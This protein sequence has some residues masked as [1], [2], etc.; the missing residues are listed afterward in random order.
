M[1]TFSEVRLADYTPPTFAIPNI[2]LDVDITRERTLVINRMTVE[3]VD[4]SV[5]EIRLN[6]ENLTLVDC[7]VNGQRILHPQLSAT[8]LILPVDRDQLEIEIHTE[9]HP[10]SN[11]A[12]MGFYQSGDIYCTQCEA[13]GFRRIT[14]FLDRPDILSRFRTTMTADRTRFPILLSNGNR[15]SK[16]DVPGHRHRVEWED[17]YPKPCYLF[18]MVAGDLGHVSDTYTTSS[19]KTVQIEFYV[20]PGNE[21][22]TGHAIESLKKSMRW[23][24]DV[25]GLEYDLD[26]YMVVAVDAFNFGAMENKGLNIFNSVYVLANPE[27]ATDLDYMNIESVI[28]HEYF[29][30]YTGNRVTCRDWFQL[31]LKEGLTVFRDQ[32]FSMDMN[33]RTY[34]RIQDVRILRE[35]Q[36]PEDAGPTS[37]PIQPVSY[38]SIDNFYT[39]TVYN[40]GAEVI[41]MLQTMLGRET[42]IHGVKTYLKIHDGTAATTDDFIAA[43]ESVSGRDLSQFKR[44]Y[45]QSGTPTIQVDRRYDEVSEQHYITFKQS[46]RNNTDTHVNAPFL[47]PMHN[48]FYTS[49]GIEVTPDQPQTELT[50]PEVTITIPSKDPII[51]SLNR[52]FA[53]PVIYKVDYRIDELM[54]L[55]AHETNM[56]SRYEAAQELWLRELIR[57][58]RDGAE[59]NADVV[60]TFAALLDSG[61]DPAMIAEMWTMPGLRRVWAA[62]DAPIPM[63]DSLNAKKRLIASIRDHIGPSLITLYQ[64]V[65]ALSE[66]D[67]INYQ[68][69]GLRL[70]KNQ[71]L[72]WL[73]PL[74]EGLAAA[75]FAG[76]K[77]MT[78][79]IGAL[80][81]LTHLPGSTRDHAMAIFYDR[82]KADSLT[83]NK[84][85]ASQA[86][87]DIP[88]ILDNIREL[89]T[90][91][92]FDRKNP[93]KIRSL[94]RTFAGNLPHFHAADGSGYE[95][96]A[97]VVIEVDGFNSNIAASLAKS[98]QLLNRLD[99]GR[100]EHMRR[101]LGRILNREDCSRD[102]NEICTLIINEKTP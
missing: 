100:R 94:Y 97:D 9:I 10:E 102:V 91:P 5:R 55:L 43:M 2:H 50:M 59:L 16:T 53:A 38:K 64:S 61:I 18:A 12:L 93:N 6:G 45:R 23:D 69:F 101:Q 74:G 11:D 89:Q 75:Q 20:D 62:F 33:N 83:I 73:G 95:F 29:H 82:W 78:D 7:F 19:G 80:N 76:A 44:W 36:Y 27:S 1:S 28:G 51:P 48:A 65:H 17:P 8:H 14:Y 46:Y 81:V 54:T 86:S 26:L 3:R 60:Q 84:Y 70:L 72:T 87:A 37:H 35:H 98:F 56:F 67:V 57:M 32:E 34:Q 92:A 68:M 99:E 77:N 88:G 71:L 41:R 42:F 47:I 66:N 49:T 52:D 79:A 96:L 21:S 4:S 30:N 22:R 90:D 15:I 63:D 24:E 40:K 25:F 39:A 31:T 13:E 85:F 58:T